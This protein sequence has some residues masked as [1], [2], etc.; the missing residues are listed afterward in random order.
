MISAENPQLETL[1]QPL[2]RSGSPTPFSGFDLV[3]YL[4]ERQQWVDAALEQSIS[5]TYPEKFTRPCA[6]L[7]WLAVS[8]YGP[9]SVWPPVR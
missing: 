1:P 2:T 6:I 3:S 9:F 8:A 7:S 4:K 5:V